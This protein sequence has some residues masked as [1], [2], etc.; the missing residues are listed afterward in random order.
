MR[1]KYI[2]LVGAS[3]ST[4]LCLLSGLMYY[5]NQGNYYKHTDGFIKQIILLIFLTSKN[6]LSLQFYYIYFY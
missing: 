4:I 5:F 6:F 2:I 3:L 1:Y